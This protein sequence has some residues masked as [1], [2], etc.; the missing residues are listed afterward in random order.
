MI[1]N[2]SNPYINKIR[3]TK[4]GSLVANI[5]IVAFAFK[6]FITLLIGL[7]SRENDL[8]DQI[9]RSLSSVV[10]FSLLGLAGF[11]VVI[12][13][14]LPQMITIRGRAAKIM[15][16]VWCGIA[17]GLAF[18]YLYLLLVKVFQI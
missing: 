9:S 12:R 5:S 14:E 3:S 11:V 10:F 16:Y 4:N 17:W 15:G 7:I 18:R 8:T 2:T 13:E 1:T 6:L